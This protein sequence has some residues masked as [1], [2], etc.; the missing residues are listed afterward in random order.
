M[1]VG[2]EPISIVLADDHE[3]VRSG[4]RLVLRPSPT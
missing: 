1:A 3:I 4:I 2:A